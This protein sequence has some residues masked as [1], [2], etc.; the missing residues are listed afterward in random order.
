M[1]LTRRRIP[2]RRG[3]LRAGAAGLALA[4]VARPLTAHIR[5]MPG[6]P[7]YPIVEA[8]YG[9]LMGATMK[10]ESIVSFRGVPYAGGT[11]GRRFRAPPPLVPWAGIREALVWG[12]QCPQ[13]SNTGTGLLSSY[14]T[15]G[16]HDE[17]CLTLNV[18]TPDPSRSRKRPVMVW[19]H[20]G[21]FE[22]GGSGSSSWYDGTRLAKRGDVVVVTVTHRLNVFG[23]L[24]LG[25]LGKRLGAVANPGMLD[26][27]AA[28]KWIQDNIEAFGGDPGSV[29]LF[30]ASGGGRKAATLMAMPEAKGLFHRVIAQSGSILRAAT[31]TEATESALALLKQLNLK[32]AE[33]AK[34]VDL[35]AAT[36]VAAREAMFASQPKVS[37]QPLSMARRCRRIRLIPQR[38][39][40]APRCP[41]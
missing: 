30:G 27:V 24:Y 22:G 25:D 40:K 32:P 19:F 23:Y 7:F 38:P 10:G 15:P 34:L 29:T 5:P 33:V 14:T 35:P 12:P 16:A 2:S 13:D 20:G 1:K 8:S 4:A 18:W 9:K 31:R 21:A 39:I 41:C 3:I 6:L 28:L 26:L 11:A 37:Y 36:L 17:N